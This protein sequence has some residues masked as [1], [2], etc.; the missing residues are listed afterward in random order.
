MNAFNCRGLALVSKV[1]DYLP[2]VINLKQPS[3]LLK[4]GTKPIECYTHQLPALI[5]W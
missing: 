1:V 3:F 5:H 4:P 2:A